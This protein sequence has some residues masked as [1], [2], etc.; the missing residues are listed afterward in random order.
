MR[1]AADGADCCAAWCREL[2]AYAAPFTGGDPASTEALVEAVF[3][4]AIAPAMSGSVVTL[5]LSQLLADVR[6]IVLAEA[7]REQGDGR[8]LRLVL[9]VAEEARVP[10]PGY[11]DEL[12]RRV[13][14]GRVGAESRRRRRGG[15]TAIVGAIA[16]VVV[17]LA[18]VGVAAGRNGSAPVAASATTAPP[19]LA[20]ASSHDNLRTTGTSVDAVRGYLLALA[21]ERYVDAASMLRG[22]AVSL[23]RRADLRPIFGKL[24]DLP[25]ALGDW[26]HTQAMCRAPDALID[27]GNEV[28]ATFRVEGEDIHQ[29]FG[30]G[31]YHGA[32]YVRGLPLRVPEPLRREQPWGLMLT[33]CPTDNVVGVISAD[34]DGDGWY[35]QVVLQNDG[36]SSGWSMTV[37]GTYLSTRLV[38]LPPYPDLRVYPVHVRDRDILLVGNE[39]ASATF[40]GQVWS[41]DV[42]RGGGGF[43]TNKFTVTPA[44]GSNLGCLDVDGDGAPEL[45]EVAVVYHGGIDAPS[46]DSAVVTSNAVWPDHVA[47]TTAETTS[48]TIGLW[49]HSP[50]LPQAF[51][52]Y[53]GDRP[54]VVN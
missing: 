14:A 3:A 34:L 2:Y 35:E 29:S 21:Q 13:E 47:A 41:F 11:V 17:F 8:R 40:R 42:D 49:P 33:L 51:D 7:N 27:N 26:C 15:R 12:V 1:S 25:S 48:E 38:H 37:C 53:C 50:S 16:G 44:Q 31:V 23:D 46:S 52:G 24:A 30:T 36:R 32:T 28:Q 6:R 45:V 18:A 39:D 54:I 5:E 43:S 19:S 9:G 10:R 4:A 22:G 20:A